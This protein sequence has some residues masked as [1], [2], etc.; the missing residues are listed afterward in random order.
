MTRREGTDV[1]AGREERKGRVI[2]SELRR[3]EV[4]GARLSFSEA[5]KRDRE[6]REAGWPN[7]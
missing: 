7:G 2:R 5:G 6:R 3:R 4:V 1:E